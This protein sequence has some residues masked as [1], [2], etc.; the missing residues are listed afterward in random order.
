M[1]PTAV[2]VSNSNSLISSSNCSQVALKPVLNSST[3]SKPVSGEDLT[4]ATGKLNSVTYITAML[5][6]RE[7]AKRE[8]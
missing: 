5:G 4:Q 6:D 7:Y 3:P 2:R 8:K 1:K